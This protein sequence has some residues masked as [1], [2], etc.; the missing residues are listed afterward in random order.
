MQ[1]IT[2]IADNCNSGPNSPYQEFKL[3][4]D[5]WL[6]ACYSGAS[7]QGS[8]NYAPHRVSGKDQARQKQ[9]LTDVVNGH[10]RSDGLAITISFVS[11]W[12]LIFCFNFL[13]FSGFG[14]VLGKEILKC[15]WSLC[16]IK[17]IDGLINLVNSR[18]VLRLAVAV[19]EWK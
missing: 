17:I 11:Q 15:S 16:K 10:L 9:G 14:C 5:H 2:S 7:R 1:P 4:L 6:C 13:N 12:L 8:P 3:S 18:T 19:F